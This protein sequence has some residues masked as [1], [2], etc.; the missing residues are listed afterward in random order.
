MKL[1][2]REQKRSLQP[3]TVVLRKKFCKLSARVDFYEIAMIIV[4]PL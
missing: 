3:E 2:S 4:L 1:I